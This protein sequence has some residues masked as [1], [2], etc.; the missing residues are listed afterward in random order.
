MSRLEEVSYMVFFG[1]TAVVG[2]VIL[3]TLLHRCHD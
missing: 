1:I 2:V 3:I